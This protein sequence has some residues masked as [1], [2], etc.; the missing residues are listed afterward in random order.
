MSQS[1]SGQSSPSQFIGGKLQ[2]SPA[3]RRA[4]VLDPSTG[5]VVA[6]VT[7]ATTDNVDRAV[8]AATAA[9]PAEM[10][11]CG[12]TTTSRSSARCRTAG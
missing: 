1:S 2:D 10:A 3:G 9:W 8:A 6:R 11:A 5:Q 7:L 4:D 12:S